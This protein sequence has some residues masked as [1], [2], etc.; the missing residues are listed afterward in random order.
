MLTY[1]A[2]LLEHLKEKLES[3]FLPRSSSW[4]H[5]NAKSLKNPVATRCGDKKAGHIFHIWFGNLFE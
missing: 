5:L 3:F 4:G 2:T 1:M